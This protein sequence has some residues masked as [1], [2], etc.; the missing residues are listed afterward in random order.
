MW[1]NLSRRRG[2]EGV[3][4]EKKSAERGLSKKRFRISYYQ[5]KE[6]AVFSQRA[7]RV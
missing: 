6:A 2:N 4:A 5:A 3:E 7:S 1:V